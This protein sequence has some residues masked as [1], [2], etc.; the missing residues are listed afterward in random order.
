M[1]SSKN[2]LSYFFLIAFGWMWLINLPRLL[3]AFTRLE[4]PAFLSTLIGYI[5][6]VGPGVAA[7][8]MTLIRSGKPGIKALWQSGWKLNF[9]KKWLLPTILLIPLSGLL[10]WVILSWL[11]V[12]IEWQYGAPAKMIIPI[13][14]LI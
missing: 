9:D 13:G 10:T 12:P 5:A 1:K 6:L 4:I 8:V 11:E 7:F 14:L 3:T 2:D